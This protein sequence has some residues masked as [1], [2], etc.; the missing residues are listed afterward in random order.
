M[1]AVKNFTAGG[2]SVLMTGAYVGSDIWNKPKT[3]QAESHFAETVMGYRLRAS[4]ASQ[5]GQ[6]VT[7]ANNCQ[8]A[9]GLKFDFHSALNSDFYAVESP[10]ALYPADERGMTVM[11]YGENA[12]PAAVASKRDGYRTVV[13]G[14][15]FE[16]VK[17]ATARD[18]LMGQMLDFLVTK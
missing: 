7:V 10:D 5:N 17:Q 2:G 11:R 13:A 1:G 6:V 16:T 14:F 18:T 3:E 9:A 15:P 4:R 12:K 8:V